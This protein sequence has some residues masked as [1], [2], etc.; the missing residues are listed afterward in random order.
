MSFLKGLMATAA[1]L[2]LAGAAQAEGE[3]HIFNWG[4]Y[5]SPEMIEKFEKAYDVKVTVDDYDSNETMLAKVRAGNSGYDIVVPTDYTVKIMIDEG[6]LA[7]TKPN[8]ME[9][10]KNVDPK[11]V[12]LY[13]DEGRNYSVPWQWGTTTFA[14]DTAVYDGDID[15]YAILFDPPEVLVDRINMQPDM[16]E[17]MNAALR[18]LG[19]PLCNGNPEDLKAAFALLKGAKPKWRTIEYGM[20]QPLVSGDIAA[21]QG[22][23][24]AAMRAREQKSSIK[25]AYPKEGFSAW[26]DNV[27]VLKD[28]PNM[29]IAKKFQ[30]FLM[31]PEN[32]AMVS[33]FAKYAN[34][35]MGSEK[36]LPASFIE[37]PEITIP[38]GAPT[39]VFV[40]LCPKEVQDKY[41]QIWTNL[42]K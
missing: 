26:M 4:N 42:L 3:L 37:A 28:A 25:Y 19:K 32:A 1:V 36:Y 18:Y 40:P 2:S 24:G 8:E 5:T 17:A 10:F 13:F 7:E 20:I 33:D 38:E 12:D 27:V 16:Y 34:G 14:V 41:T 39:P 29:E 30:N 21:S 6:L 11:W 22:W 15:S 23:N 9:N 31:D 35:I